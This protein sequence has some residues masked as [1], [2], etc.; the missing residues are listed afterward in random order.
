MSEAIKRYGKILVLVIVA[1]AI[2]T[3]VGFLVTWTRGQS[4][5]IVDP[6]SFTNLSTLPEGTLSISEAMIPVEKVLSQRMEEVLT[7]RSH[8]SRHFN[9]I[10]EFESINP[11]NGQKYIEERVSRIIE[12]GTGICYLDNQGRWAITNP[13]WRETPNGFV[14]DQAGYTLAIGRT[15]DSYLTYTVDQEILWL[16]ASAIKA[17]AGDR[18]ETLAIAN[19]QVQAYIDAQNPQRLVFPDAFGEGFD[20][21][22]V[23]E[24]DGFHQDVIFHTSPLLPDGMTP[25]QTQLMVYTELAL[26][27]Y[28]LKQNMSFVIGAKEWSI[29][30]MDLN[31]TPTRDDIEFLK[32]V[33]EEDAFYGYDRHRFTA[34]KIYD[35]GTNRSTPKTTAYKQLFRDDDD[36]VYLIET[37]EGDFFEKASYPVTWDYHTING[38][39]DP[40]DN[41]WYAKNTYYVSSDFTVTDGELLIEPGTI[42]KFADD[43]QLIA[44]SDGRIIAK[45][46]PYLPIL[47]TSVHDNNNGEYISGG[48]PARDDWGGLVVDEGSEIEFCLIYYADPGLDIQGIPAIPIR[49]NK[50]YQCGNGMDIDEN[51]V[52]EGESL[53]LFNNYFTQID[54]N[55]VTIHGEDGDILV[56]NHFMGGMTKAIEIDSACTHTITIDNTLMLNCDYGLYH[57]PNNNGA[58][59]AN[60]Y[61]GYYNIIVDK[62]YDLQIGNNSVTLTT[63]PQHGV[64]SSYNELGWNYLNKEANGGELIKDAGSCTVAEAGYEDPC[65]WSIYHVPGDNIHGFYSDTTLSTDTTWEPDYS[66][67]DT[68]PVAIGYHYPRV[69]YL[70]DEVK[71]TV[72]GG[73]SP[74]TLEIKPGTVIAHRST[75]SNDYLYI[76]SGD[77][78]IANGDLYTDNGM[79]TWVECMRIG[80]HNL[81]LKYPY[82]YGYRTLLVYNADYE[83][84]ANRFLGLGYTL[85][86]YYNSS[87][88]IRDC[89]FLLN[90]YGPFYQSSSVSNSHLCQNS[91]FSANLYGIRVSSSSGTVPVSNCTF[92]D[93]IYGLSLGNSNAKATNCLFHNNS[94]YGITV[95]NSTLDETYN[96]FRYQTGQ[97]ACGGD[98]LDVT[99]WANPA[100][101]YAQTYSGELLVEDWTNFSDRFHLIEGCN[102]VDGGYDS[103]ERSMPGYTTDINDAMDTAPIDMGFHYPVKVDTDEDGLYDGE[104]YW[105]GTDPQD[106]DSDDDG[107][108]DYDEIYIY[109]TGP[110]DE[111]TDDD[112]IDDGLEI[113]YSDQYDPDFDPLVPEDVNR[114]TDGDG[115]S[116]I[117]EYLQTGFSPTDAEDLITD[118]DGDGWLDIAERIRGTSTTNPNPPDGYPTCSTLYVDCAAAPDVQDGSVV[119]P[120][121]TIQLAIHSSGPGDTII[122]A[123]GVYTSDGNCDLNFYG[124][125]NVILQSDNGVLSCIIDCAGS[126]EEPHRGFKFHT[127]EDNSIVINGFTIQNGYATESIGNQG[128]GIYCLET[129][130]TIRNCIVQDCLAQQGGGIF[131]LGTDSENRTSPVITN[132][133]ITGNEGVGAS[134]GVRFQYCDGLLKNCVISDNSAGWGGGIT[135]VQSDPEIINCTF[136][137]NYASAS[138]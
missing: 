67:C 23:A 59:I 136:V 51:A 30:G 72:D 16:R 44:G 138:G 121:T 133:I 93:N 86:A 46:D 62:T 64:V 98:T 96:I 101:D 118:T 115:I 15:L 65:Q 73:G 57:Y 128:G 53:T 63:S 49:H 2:I 123:D 97:S 122:V 91:L 45:G 43:T 78:I 3:L 80:L 55:G 117:W 131:C 119:H 85:Y 29:P 68:G 35:A 90:T 50:F 135:C 11:E 70:I 52:G 12:V 132:C 14:M 17:M 113:D 37:L 109:G 124:R 10:R 27:H 20:L 106:E 100:T 71:V 22:L 134:G 32:V 18:L 69:E 102:A 47:F 108:L 36:K 5:A 41:V 112:R 120:Y 89:Q 107:L 111:D 13:Q 137:S 125:T 24:P 33:P 39:F 26:D 75:S 19:E 114:D 9:V 94:T 21:V 110:L 58:N 130:P 31:T 42:V 74:A 81:P 84:V 4:I 82:Y 8:N 126:V 99:D 116:D 105:L 34:S 83:L 87:G 104:E 1:V 77:N 56:R 28:C 127:G 95:Y 6:N 60:D 129:S 40:C 38:V 92:V 103:D 48:S 88:L 25:D 7:A 79:I 61:N 66:T 54:D 76:T